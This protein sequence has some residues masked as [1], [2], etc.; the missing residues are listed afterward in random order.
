MGQYSTK[1]YQLGV[2]TGP[3]V[4]GTRCRP[5]THAIE[6]PMEARLTS[7]DRE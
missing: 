4:F 1:H 5:I 6:M 2:S 7:H 3:R